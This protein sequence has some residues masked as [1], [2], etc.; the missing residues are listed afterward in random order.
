M[1]RKTI[2]RSSLIFI[3]VL[4]IFIDAPR[5]VHAQLSAIEKWIAPLS[6]E[7]RIEVNVTY[8]VVNNYE[9][10][11]DVVVP[12]DATNLHPTVISIHGGSWRGGA[13]EGQFLKFL[14]YLARGW[15]VVNVEYRLAD[16]ALAPGAVEDCRCALW[17]VLRNAEEY[18]FDL[19]KIVVTGD[20]AGGHLALTT[21]MMPISAGFD[22]HCPP[23]ANSINS[24]AHTTP[25][26]Q[27]RPKVAAIINWYGITDVVDYMEA[28][29]ADFMEGAEPKKLR[30]LGWLG[31]QRDGETI[32]K[33]VSPLTYV[34]SGLPPIL[35][36]HG[37][38]DRVVPYSHAVRLH[39]ALTK[40]GVPNQLITIPQGGHGKFSRQE[41][42]QAWEGIWSFLAK[43][44]Y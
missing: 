10:K 37:D 22:W 42:I 33:Q 19:E 40:A 29:I 43:H 44:I 4:A 2:K 24:D 17:W 26:N 31:S 35:T 27:T 3:C 34:E 41:M 21:G 38:A 11:L 13:K 12:R 28:E 14:P 5:L 18:K 25:L 8:H 15:A 7:Y 6:N 20:S 16:A 39:E 1:K 23:I 30:A 36:I 9:V 32:A